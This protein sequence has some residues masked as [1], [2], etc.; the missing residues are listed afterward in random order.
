LEQVLWNVLQNALIYTPAATP[1]MIAAEL[2]P[3]TLELQVGD[4]GPGIPAGEHTRV[5]EKFYRP[6]HA[7]PASLQ[8]A[9]VGLAICK[10]LI[11]AHAGTIA[12][13]D[14]VGGGTLVRIRLP[15]HADIPQ[16]EGLLWQH[17]TS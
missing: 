9:G 1:I 14:R 2:H 15:L 4:R 13:F 8:G 16:K 17:H 11:E 12:I 6:A 10:G 3:G 5:F 7:H